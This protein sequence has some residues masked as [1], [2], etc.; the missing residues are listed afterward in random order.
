MRVTVTLEKADI[1]V[2]D[3]K[4][5]DGTTIL[6]TDLLMALY[7]VQLS[8]AKEPVQLIGKHDKD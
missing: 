7:L 6:G 1:R 3:D 4:H 5:S 2:A 8:S